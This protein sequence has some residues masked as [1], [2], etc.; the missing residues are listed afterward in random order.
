VI[1]LSPFDLLLFVIIGCGIGFLAGLFGLG[2]GFIL[3]P[4]LIFSYERL[5]VSYTVLT[6]LAVGTSLFVII[7]TS[8]ASTYQQRKQKNIDWHAVLPL[9]FSSAL[10]AL[11]TSKLAALLSGR[12]LKIA[13]AIIALIAAIRMLTESEIQEEKKL[14]LLY[15]SNSFGFIGVGLVAGVVSALA[16]VGGGIFTIPMMYYFLNM[17]L[18]LAIGTS[19]ATIIITSIFS[20]AGYILNGMG[21]P[22]LPRWSLG[23]VDLQRGMA[24]AIGTVLLAR[25]GAYVSFRTHPVLLRRFFAIFISL[26]SIY[27]LLK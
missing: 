27:L 18:K 20:T 19:S 4:V 17:P 11:A 22:D 5:G 24:L 12:S 14:K 2:G 7:F 9:G 8:L 3:I 13:F 6:H 21:H 16:G 10:T 25:V 15:H 26:I 1:G 23:F